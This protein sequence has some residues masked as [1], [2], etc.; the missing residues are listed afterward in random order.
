MTQQQIKSLM[1][2]QWWSVK[3][4]NQSKNGTMLNRADLQNRHKANQHLIFCYIG[5]LQRWYVTNA[6][7][8]TLLENGYKVLW[9]F[10]KQCCSVYNYK[11]LESTIQCFTVFPIK[12]KN[13]NKSDHKFGFMHLSSTDYSQIVW[14]YI[15]LGYWWSFITTSVIVWRETTVLLSTQFSHSS[16]SSTN[17]K[18]VKSTINLH[19]CHP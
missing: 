9:C 19:V 11:H 5:S 12:Y 6:S 10:F 7:L 3:V 18:R 15:C 2:K 13:K 1:L 16:L 8:N 14:V 4:L 17:R